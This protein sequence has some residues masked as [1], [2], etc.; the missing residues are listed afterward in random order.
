[1]DRIVLI[2]GGTGIVQVILGLRSYR[3][4]GVTTVVTIA[5][6]GRRSG[7]LR[8][9]LGV[10]PPGDL[11]NSLYAMANEEEMLQILSHQLPPGTLGS[12]HGFTLGHLYLAIASRE[13]GM[14]RAVDLLSEPLKVNSKDRVLAVSEQKTDLVAILADGSKIVGEANIDVPKHNPDIPIKEIFLDPPVHTSERCVQEIVNARKIVI[15]PGDLF[16]SVVPNL[17]V[18]G[19]PEAIRRAK[20][21]GAVVIYVANLMTKRGETDGYTV[22]DFV[23]VVQRYLGTG[24]DIVICDSTPRLPEPIREAYEKE[25]KRVV[26]LDPERL[27]GLKVRV[28]PAE[29]RHTNDPGR[30]D[31]NKL[32][33][34]IL[35]AT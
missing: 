10:L 31:P 32:A 35:R 11:L 33:E 7:E 28:I 5:D 14:Q 23:S 4:V 25:G 3:Q 30:H 12:N 22:G 21:K 19:I 27:Q 1:M 20:E 16:T 18:K 8:T 15:G 9:Q 26:A 29:L 24:V 13:V 2:G 17:L 6:S 34:A